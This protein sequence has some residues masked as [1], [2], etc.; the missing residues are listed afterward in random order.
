MAEKLGIVESLLRLMLLLC[1]SY[2]LWRVLGLLVELIAESL[3]SLER[4]KD[5]SAHRHGLLE[6]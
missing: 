6:V 5:G 3:R 2:A 1:S 4:V